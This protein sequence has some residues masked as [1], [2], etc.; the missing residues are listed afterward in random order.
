MMKFNFSDLNGTPI[1]VSEFKRF[2]ALDDF[3]CNTGIA[4]EILGF[5]LLN[6]ILVTIGIFLFD[7]LHERRSF[8]DLQFLEE[9]EKVAYVIDKI[10]V[11]LWLLNLAP[12]VFHFIS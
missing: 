9:K 10:L 4:S 1:N 2:S 11:F 5:S 12:L 8:K 6:L 3:V 7:K